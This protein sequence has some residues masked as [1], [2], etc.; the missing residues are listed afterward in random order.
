M[1]PDDELDQGLRAQ[2]ERF[3][4]KVRGW[5]SKPPKAESVASTSSLVDASTD[6][7][8][9]RVVAVPRPGMVIRDSWKLLEPLGKGGFGTVF[10]ARH[11]ALERFDAIKF[12][13]PHLAD[14]EGI[15][16]RFHIE[17]KT[18]ARLRGEHLVQV[19][20]YG[21]HGPLPF[22]VMERLT[23]ESLHALL[24]R[25]APLPASVFFPIAEGILRGL[26]E[27]HAHGIVHRDV[28]PGN[29]FVEGASRQIKILDFG[30]AKTSLHITSHNLKIGTPVYMAPELLLSA[31]A[32]ASTATDLYSAGVVLYQML[33]GRLPFRFDPQGGMMGLVRQLLAANPQAPSL[34]DDPAL[35]AAGELVLRAIDRDPGRRPESAA[36]FVEAL[37]DARRSDR[38]EPSPHRS[39][40]S[41]APMPG[42]RL[43]HLD[44]VSAYFYLSF[45]HHDEA[46]AQRVARLAYDEH[47]LLWIG[48][49]GRRRPVAPIRETIE[50]ALG[51]VVIAS[52]DSKRASNVSEDVELA[53]ALGKPVTVVWA[54]GDLWADCIDAR[55]S[56]ARC[57]DMRGVDDEVIGDELARMLLDGT[58][59]VLPTN[60]RVGTTSPSPDGH[61]EMREWVEARRPIPPGYLFVGDPRAPGTGH[62]LYLRL[63]AHHSVRQVL[64]VVYL[65]LLAESLPPFCY[66]EQ[67]VLVEEPFSVFPIAP[68]AAVPSWWPGRRVLGKTEL[69]RWANE[70]TPAEAGMKPIGGRWR[71]ERTSDE[72]VITTVAANEA[73]FFG[74]VANLKGGRYW[75]S[76]ESGS[77]FEMLPWESFRESSYHETRCYAHPIAKRLGAEGHVIVQTREL[78]LE[79]AETG[80]ENLSLKQLREWMIE[81]IRCDS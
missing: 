78:G 66:G 34:G 13:H 41:H 57:I 44:T 32:S 40:P 12:L 28:K 53:I 5:G 52:P 69:K 56:G 4:A 47:F 75:L 79:Q 21:M 55:A 19:H 22:F 17:A 62:G 80:R 51:V 73:R 64:D 9:A 42:F 43:P 20:D 76:Q 67:W 38:H 71:I 58:R 35:R 37:V 11:L 33:A 16:E 81:T 8:E 74:L 63:A 31:D 72:L 23:G 54:K 50:S 46:A 2:M 18:M 26:A 77:C 30:L 39:P 15:R 6:R 24:T 3:L 14:D 70:T 10:E 49:G 48:T 68:R 65:S 61:D 36:A 25:E 60:F 1:D 27:I 29:V 59:R 45:S 7:A